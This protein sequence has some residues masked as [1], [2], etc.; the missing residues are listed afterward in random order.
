MNKDL[1]EPVDRHDKTSNRFKSVLT[2]VVL[3]LIA[4]LLGLVPMWWKSR[5]CASELTSSQNALL[6][7]SLQNTLANAGADARRGDY[8]PARQATS[9]FFTKL[10][11]EV[12]RGSSSIFNEGQRNNLSAVFSQRYDT[13]TLLA[14]SDPASIDRLTDLY[15]KYR[16]VAASWKP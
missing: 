2:V 14:R 15:Q 16:Q 8:E 1:N 10:R 13:V 5:T 6:I 12:D 9:E 7:S 11:A 3:F 4:F